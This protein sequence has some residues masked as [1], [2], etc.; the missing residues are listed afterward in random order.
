DLEQAIKAVCDSAEQEVSEGAVLVVLSDKGLEKGK[1]PIPAAMLVGAVQTRLADT[2]LRCDANI[3]VET[4]TARDPHQ[5]AVLLGFGATA[6]Y[7]YLAYEA[8]GK[9]LDDGSLDKDYR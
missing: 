3:V 5:F 2:N 9:M 7:P 4:A 6:V 8:L 1:L